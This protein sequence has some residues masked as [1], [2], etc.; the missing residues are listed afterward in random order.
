MQNIPFPILKEQKLESIAERVEQAQKNGTADTIRLSKGE[1]RQSLPEITEHKWFLSE[2]LGRDVGV[3]VAALDFRENIARLSESRSAA[4]TGRGCGLFRRL[5]VLFERLIVS[6][7]LYAFASVQSVLRG[8]PN[9][10]VNSAQRGRS[11]GEDAG[12]SAHLRTVRVSAESQ[13][14][15]AAAIDE[16][17]WMLSERLGRDVGARVAA[18]DYVENIKKIETRNS[19]SVKIARSLECLMEASGPHSIANLERAVRLSR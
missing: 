10:P 14:R 15:F 13:N 6:D 17:K 5:G 19:F 11:G 16:H 4:K 12:L 2:R 8:I 1:I 9:S 18:L 3:A 7:G